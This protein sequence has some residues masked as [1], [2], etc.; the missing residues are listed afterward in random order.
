LSI[1]ALRI[2]PHH[3]HLNLDEAL[4]LVDIIK[5]GV[6]YLSH[7]SHYLGFHDEVEKKLPK[8]VH[9]AYDNLVISV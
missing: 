4:K 9:L 7:I 5:P 6:A 2:D 8:N 1:N 3:S